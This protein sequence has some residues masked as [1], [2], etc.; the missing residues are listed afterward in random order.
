MLH[1]RCHASIAS[2]RREH[3][4]GVRSPLPT[5]PRR[6]AILHHRGSEYA[7]EDLPE[8]PFHGAAEQTGRGRE[9]YLPLAT[10]FRCCVEFLERLMAAEMTCAVD[11]DVDWRRMTDCM[12]Q[13][14]C[15]LSGVRDIHFQGLRPVHPNWIYVPNPDLG[16]SLDEL[17]CNSSADS[18][19][20][21]GDD[22]RLTR[23][24][25]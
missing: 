6:Q 16:A 23:K 12:R 14:R 5:P 21:T 25:V 13:C 24:I 2:S 11:Q 4:T 7:E 8:R 18:A 3:R 1:R 20:T 10:A 9:A 22:R 15:D 17:R 19:S